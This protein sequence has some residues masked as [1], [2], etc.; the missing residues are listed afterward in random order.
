MALPKEPRQKM[1]NIMYL[2]LTAM[3]A[4][5]VS[6]EILNAFDIVNDSIIT[7]NKSIDT[8]NNVTY[9]QF[10]KQVA[11]DAAKA[12]PY[13]EKADKVK[14][15]AAEA[16][17]YIERLKD[18]IIMQSD[19]LDK[20]PAD[21]QL[22]KRDDLDAPT[23]IMEN[24]KS[25]PRLEAMLKELRVNMLNQV[26]PKERPAM[27]KNFPLNIQVGHAKTGHGDEKGPKSWTVYHFNMVPSIAAITILSKFQ[28]DIKNS[29]SMIIDEL[30]K[31]IGANDIRFDAMEAFV[32]MNSKNFTPG[33]QLEAKIAI[34][35][36]STTVNPEIIVNGATLPVVNGIATFTS[37]TGAVGEHRL[38]GSISLKKPNGETITRQINEVYNVG[39]SATAVSADKMNVL[40]IAVGN[41]ISI[42]IAGTPAEAVSARIEGSPGARIEKTA[43]GK[44]VAHVTTPGKC[45]IVPISGDGKPMEGKEYRVK[46][47]PD[48]IAMVGLAKSG[49]V[50]TADFKA[51][52]GV[53]A[54]LENFEFEGVRYDV[55]GFRIGV[56]AKGKDYVDEV[57]NSPIFPGP[58]QAAIRSLKPGDRVYI[59]NIKVKGPDG[60]VRE[61]PYNLT[62]NLN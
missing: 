6:A 59:E 47:I 29:E 32:S 12:G 42:S 18:T 57:A 13:K 3:L 36:Y 19:K 5:N 39:A 41:P 8:K 10:A 14:Q 9:D 20:V 30:F 7:S 45:V 11:E 31:E 61:I 53:R 33:Q 15:L 58:A 21:K 4:M 44:F 56:D 23:R 49:S 2:V 54:V 60:K 26:D 38:T 1:I 55:M 50:K 43:P 46:M 52:T 27:E 40:Y 62:Y 16:V 51:Q 37:Q 34:G 48:P 28:N 35:A 17:A 25:G 24:G 22:V